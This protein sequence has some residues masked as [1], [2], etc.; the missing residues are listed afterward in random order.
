MN[1]AA[2]FNCY[3]FEFQGRISN[4]VGFLSARINKGNAPKE[5]SEALK[6]ITAYMAFHQNV[7]VAMRTPLQHL[8][9]SLFVNLAN[10]VLIHR[11][12]YLEH[13]KPGIKPD[14]WNL[15]RNAPI[16]GYGLFPDS[17][18]CTTEQDIGKHES[19]GV[20]PGPGLSTSQRPGWRGNY[21]Y[22]P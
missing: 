7:S 16:F 21:R 19:A 9:D 6:D 20:I 18:L 13:V 3:S 1:S 22:K 15:L 5:V 17:V 11:D 8:A 2:S 10:L 4:N 14:T 12:S